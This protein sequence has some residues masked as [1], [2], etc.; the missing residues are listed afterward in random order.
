MVDKLQQL[1][2][3]NI[4][5]IQSNLRLECWRGAELLVIATIRLTA[6]SDRSSGCKCENRAGKFGVPDPLLAPGFER[7]AGKKENGHE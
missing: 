1:N 7:K 2:N 5:L 6:A 3:E 4:M